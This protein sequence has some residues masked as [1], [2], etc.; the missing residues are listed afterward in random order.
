VFECLH[1]RIRAASVRVCACVRFS[2]CMCEGGSP[3]VPSF[4]SLPQA[5]SSEFIASRDR[6]DF[7]CSRIPN[8]INQR[9]TMRPTD[10]PRDGLLAH[11]HRPRAVTAVG[12]LSFTPVIVSAAV[13]VPPLAL[14]SPQV[15]P[16]VQ[17]AAAAVATGARRLPDP[18]FGSSSGFLFASCVL[19]CV[20]FSLWEWIYSTPTSKFFTNS[21]VIFLNFSFPPIFPFPVGR[22][23]RAD[24]Q[25]PCGGGQ[26]GPEPLRGVQAG[27]GCPLRPPGPGHPRP[28][29]APPPNLSTPGPLRRPCTIFGLFLFFC[30]DSPIIR[31]TNKSLK[32]PLFSMPC[33][34]STVDPRQPLLCGAVVK[35]GCVRPSRHTVDSLRAFVE[36]NAHMLSTLVAHPAAGRPRLGR[37][38]GGP[39][40]C[41]FGG[42]FRSIVR[43][44]RCLGQ[45]VPA[46]SFPKGE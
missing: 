30:V 5:P 6:Y 32:P 35:E 16:H 46:V 1:S 17:E 20:F 25:R 10:G 15:K 37:N 31:K 2:V 26:G 7:Y 18:R 33:S 28:A 22:W 38:A 13:S 41:G 39:V 27:V 8:N 9:H 11:T 14:A 45:S 21:I 44:L 4:E 3:K 42:W 36:E 12:S 40:P 43:S 23:P 19:F 34:P 24:T 29:Q